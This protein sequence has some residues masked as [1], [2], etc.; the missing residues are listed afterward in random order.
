MPQSPNQKVMVPKR[1]W[2]PLQ[3]H[4]RL[5]GKCGTLVPIFVAEVIPGTKCFIKQTLGV[6]LPPLASDTYMSVSYKTEAFFTPTRLLFGGAEIDGPA[7][8]Q[9]QSSAPPK[10]RR[11]GVK[12]A[13]VL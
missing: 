1:S 10:S 9:N 2:R 13:S 11:V 4:N 5:T 3:K 12:N 6:T 8:W 7:S